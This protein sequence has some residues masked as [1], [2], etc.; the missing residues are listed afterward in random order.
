[1]RQLLCLFAEGC[2]AAVELSEH[3]LRK[4][5]KEEAPVQLTCPLHP[6]LPAGMH[7][8]RDYVSEWKESPSHGSELLLWRGK[9]FH[10]TPGRCECGTPILV[11]FPVQKADLFPVSL[12]VASH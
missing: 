4:N 12:G 1:M 3:A 8:L 10:Y 11:S 7:P 9:C 5:G 2:A 6:F